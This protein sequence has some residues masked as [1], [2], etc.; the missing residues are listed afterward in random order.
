MSEVVK[1]IVVDDHP[2]F[3]RATKALLEQIDRIEVVAVAS[4]AKQCLEQIEMYQ[5]GLVFLDYQLPD[6]TGTGRGSD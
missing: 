4:D 6:Q 1:T 3:A 2:L 5:P